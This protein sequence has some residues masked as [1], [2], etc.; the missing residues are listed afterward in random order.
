MELKCFPLL[1]NESKKLMKKRRCKFGKKWGLTYHYQPQTRL[2]NRLA[3]ELKMS[4][5]DVRRQIAEERLYLLR[6][7]YGNTITSKDI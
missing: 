6:E 2:I 1:G 4:P 3:T 7:I 5:Q